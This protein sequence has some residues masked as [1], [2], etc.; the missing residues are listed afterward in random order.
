MFKI[1]NLKYKNILDVKNLEIRSNIVTTIVGKSG[2]GKTTL[3]KLLNKLISPES[4]KV[5]YLGNDLEQVDSI[6][7]RRNVVMLSQ[8]PVV[9]AGSVK[10]NL[11]IGLDFSEKPHPSDDKL[12]EVLHKVHLN[13]SLSADADKLSGGEKRRLYLL[14]L[15][16]Q[17]PNVLL[18]DEPTND[19]DIFALCSLDRLLPTLDNLNLSIISFGFL[20]P[21]C[22]LAIFS[23]VSSDT[24]LPV[25]A[26]MSA[27]AVCGSIAF[28]LCASDNLFLCSSDA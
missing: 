9:F 21:L 8:T 3:L 1:E 24:I 2:S 28:P 22:L 10:D 19:L 25:F 20:I 26:A 14:R 18:L 16:L 13:L 5:Y 12:I 4:G 17:Q 11:L 6:A 15:L 7:H 27:A 23:L